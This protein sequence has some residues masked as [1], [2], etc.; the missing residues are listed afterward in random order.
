MWPIPVHYD[1]VSTGGQE[2]LSWTLG[3]SVA[4]AIFVGFPY[5]IQDLF[6]NWGI[7]IPLCAEIVLKF[8]TI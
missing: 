7:F 8:S 3:G 2:G 5:C 1:L 6:K 4:Y